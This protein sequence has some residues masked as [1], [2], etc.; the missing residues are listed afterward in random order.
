[1]LYY[2]YNILYIIYYIYI[3]LHIIYILYRIYYIYNIIYIHIKLCTHKYVYIVGTCLAFACQFQSGSPR[4]W[5]ADPHE[6][7][8]QR[9]PDGAAK[10]RPSGVMS[11]GWVSE[12]HQ[13]KGSERRN[14]TQLFVE[15]IGISPAKYGIYWTT[16]SHRC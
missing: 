16:R 10:P 1:M 6:M 2:I 13:Q 9:D 12:F 5:T 15:Q 11:C 7:S 8:H 14:L 3:I 4:I